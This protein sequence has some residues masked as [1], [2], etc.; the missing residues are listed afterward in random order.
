VTY[1]SQE[2]GDHGPFW[3]VA[4]EKEKVDVERQ[5]CSLLFLERGIYKISR[6]IL[7]LFVSEVQQ[8]QISDFK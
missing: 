1:K 7:V 3:A 8:N 4:P 2:R 6:E 5:I